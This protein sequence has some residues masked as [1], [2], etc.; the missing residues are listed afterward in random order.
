MPRHRRR[1]LGRRP[2]D[3]AQAPTPGAASRACR[4]GRNG[5]EYVGVGPVHATPPSRTLSVGFG[6]MC[7]RRRRPVRFPSFRSAGGGAGPHFFPGGKKRS[8]LESGGGAGARHAWP[9]CGRVDG[10]E[11]PGAACRRLLRPAGRKLMSTEPTRDVQLKRRVAD[12][13]PAGRLPATRPLRCLVTNHAG[14]WVE[15]STAEILARTSHGQSKRY[16]AP[17]MA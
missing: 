5:C 11:D 10:A 3:R 6:P 8:T 15:F 9:W 7:A 13:A 14:W 2:P 1:L 16:R 17:L 4:V 12:P